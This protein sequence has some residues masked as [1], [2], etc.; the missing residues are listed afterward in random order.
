MIL[1]EVMERLEQLCP[2]SFAEDWDNS[3]LQLGRTSQE[4]EKIL[5]C[6]DVTTQTVEQAIREGCDLIVAHHPLLFNGL[7]TVSDLDFVGRRAELLIR[8]GIAC[9]AMHT[10]FDVIGMA[11]AAADELDLMD[12]EVLSVTFEDDVSREGLGRIGRLRSHMALEDLAAEVRDAFRLERVRVYGDLRQPVVTAAV[13]PGSGADE[14]DAAL[15]AGADVMIT[16]DVSHHRGIDA[17]EKGIAVIDA[18]HY[19]LERIFLPYM[20]DLIRREMPEMA[21]VCAEDRQPYAEI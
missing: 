20:Q 16:G 10:N 1:S 8:S 2:L 21:V 12:R 3:G 5:I 4:I 17:V 9:Y 14:I 19:G 6:V 15:K 7:K 11:D 13:L 18:G